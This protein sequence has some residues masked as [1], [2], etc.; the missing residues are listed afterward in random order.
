MS[1]TLDRDAVIDRFHEAVNMTGAELSRWLESDDSKAVGWKGEDGKGDEESVGHESGRRIV[2][3]LGKNKSELTDDD[4]HHMHR[5]VSYV[6]RHM[7][8]K[9]AH[10]EGSRWAYSLMNWCHDPM[11][12]D[13]K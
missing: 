6:A 13:K 5:V 9:P 1:D 11:K 10:P 12:E 4:V 8:Q 7:A 3:L 2:E